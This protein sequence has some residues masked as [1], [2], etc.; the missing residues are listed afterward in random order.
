MLAITN[1]LQNEITRKVISFEWRPSIIIK[2][3]AGTS[4]HTI[5][6][7]GF[8]FRYASHGINIPIFTRC[9]R[10]FNIPKT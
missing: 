9:V 6:S 5:K 1:Y 4:D 8:T 10:I 7:Q 3:F 2:M